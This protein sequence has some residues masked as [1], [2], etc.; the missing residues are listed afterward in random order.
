MLNIRND[1]LSLRTD[2]SPKFPPNFKASNLIFW[3]LLEYASLFTC[4]LGE[5]GAV[6]CSSLLWMCT[7][8]FYYSLIIISLC[9]FNAYQMPVIHI[10]TNCKFS[11]GHQGY[12]YF[13]CKFWA[14]PPFC[15]IIQTRVE[16]TVCGCM[17]LYAEGHEVKTQW[18]LCSN[19]IYVFTFFSKFWILKNDTSIQFNWNLCSTNLQILEAAVLLAKD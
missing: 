3:H 8:E 15:C 5:N 2:V 1:K 19:K 9:Q 11:C 16:V 6:S 12:S 13:S 18:G 7:L 4:Q 10:W 14:L 17:M